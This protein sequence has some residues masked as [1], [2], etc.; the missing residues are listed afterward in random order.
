MLLL[1]RCRLLLLLLL[2]PVALQ[3]QLVQ[4]SPAVLAPIQ[5]QAVHSWV[6]R[7]VRG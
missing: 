2:L 6:E 4:G 1:L 7:L 3:K 5:A